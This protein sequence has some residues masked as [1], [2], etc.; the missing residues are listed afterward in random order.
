MEQG[1]FASRTP[2]IRKKHVRFE[3][4]RKT[5][6]PIREE[7]VQVRQTFANSFSLLVLSKNNSKLRVLKRGA[8]ARF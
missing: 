3:L 7:R 1:K 2:N 4:K 6:N 8:C 5:D